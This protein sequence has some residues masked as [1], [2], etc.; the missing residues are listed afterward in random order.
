MTKDGESAPRPCPRIDGAE[1]V[2]E[3]CADI[4]SD[5]SR[6]AAE[7]PERVYFPETTADVAAAV[8]EAVEAGEPL[9]ISGARTGIVG[10]A[11][12]LDSRWVLSLSKMDRLI[13]IATG[14]TPPEPY[15]RV[16]AG[17]TL[18]SLAEELAAFDW[19]PLAGDGG[20]KSWFY[21]V[22]PT[23]STA[24]VG[25][26]VATNAS[27]GRSYRYGS[28]R[29]WVRGLEVV[30]ADGRT[31]RLR[32]GETFAS[33]GVLDAPDVLGPRKL[34]LPD[35]ARPTCKCACGYLVAPDV[36]L[37]D[38]F[39]GSEGTLGVVTEV[40]LRLAP[41]PENILALMCFLPEGPGGAETGLALV[42]DLKADERLAPL[43]I[44]YFGGTALDMLREERELASDDRIPELPPD[45]KTAVFLEVAYEAEEELDA[46]VVAI[47]ERLEEH[48]GSLEKT[49]AGDEPA[50]R[51]KMRV[52]RHSVPEA[53]NNRVARRKRDVPELHK[54]GTDLAVPDEALDD[55]LAA[56]HELIPESGLE[57]VIFGHAGENHLHVNLIPRSGRDLERA[58]A[59]HEDLARL[60]VRLGGSVTAEHGVGRLKRSLLEIQYG[61][62]GVAA[63]KRVKDFFDPDSLLNPGVLFPAADRRTDG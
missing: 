46:L 36:D 31:V 21:P 6:L 30:L 58:K 34:E 42:K 11:V 37:V 61:P 39:V 26:T 38:V 28:T 32:R 40:E 8:R 12:P 63:L 43:T 56:Y 13:E 51:E 47:D 9:T 41:T 25:G 49:W 1:A 5:E 10:G 2:L 7:A 59:L 60:V 50:T 4:L 3:R 54:V 48:G 45:A 15:A 14:G 20:P 23:E 16:Q 44:E 29:A 62:E 33:A 55:L 17:M 27:G 35:V 52:L 53:A 57:Y 19:K 22:D 24:F 18:S